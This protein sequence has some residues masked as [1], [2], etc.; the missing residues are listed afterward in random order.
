MKPSSILLM[1]FTKVLSVCEAAI[2]PETKK[3]SRISIV[4]ALLL[5]F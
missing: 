3:A 4:H 1:L 5:A 2:D